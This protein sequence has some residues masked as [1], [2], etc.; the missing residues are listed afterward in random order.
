M[1]SR[2]SFLFWDRGPDDQ[3]LALAQQPGAL[4]DPAELERQARRLLASPG[5]NS[6]VRRFYRELMEG[7]GG[8]VFDSEVPEFD[9][10]ILALMDEEFGTFV[11][12]AT[13]DAPHDF[14][15]LFEPVTWVNGPLATFYGFPGVEGQGFQ[16]VQ[17][18]P[19]TYAGLLTSP[20]W[21]TRASV[22]RFTNPSLRGWVI[23]RAL[24]CLDIPP[25]PPGVRIPEPTMPGMTSR[26]RAA[27]HAESPAC[28]GCH[29]YI[30]PL[31]FGLEHFDATG[32]YRDT[33]NE[34]PIDATGSLPPDGVAFNGAG[35]LAQL[36]RSTED[37]RNCFVTQWS[38]FAFGR[39]QEEAN[40]CTRTTLRDQFSANDDVLELLVNLT[41]STSFRFRAQTG[42]QP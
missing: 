23:A 29:A 40:E 35:E 9:K 37:T 6:V 8:V 41:Q 10:S 31:G 7:H 17:L 12:H 38:R 33:E 36:M 18:D 32:R 5:A 16:P 13:F 22:P 24:R 14:D 34:L 11:D 15:A 2:L 30:D 1:A 25:E 20:A 27:V 19:G 26:G 42:G 3:L 4:H 21:L 28:A 39:A